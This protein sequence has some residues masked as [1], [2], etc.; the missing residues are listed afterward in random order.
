[1]RRREKPCIA[2]ATLVAIVAWAAPAR[3][4]SIAITYTLIG[5]GTVQSATDTT[6]TLVASANGSFLSGNAGQDAAWNPISYSD[7]SIL[8]FTTNLL[9]GVFTLTLADG[10]TLTGDVFEDQTVPDTSPSQTGPFS[11]VLTFTGGTGAF[12]G[13]TGSVSGQGFLGTTV[14]AVSASGTVNTSAVPEPA[15]AALLIGGLALICVKRWGRLTVRS[16]FEAHR[17]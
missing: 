10:D 17:E 1:M 6:L 13:A 11:Q 14:F 12:A 5:T 3:G 7:T 2:A 16:A 9:N 8:D 4:D 15:P